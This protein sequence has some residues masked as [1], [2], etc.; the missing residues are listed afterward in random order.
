MPCHR[1]THTQTQICPSPFLFSTPPLSPCS[2]NW[3]T[4]V[5]TKFVLQ[6]LRQKRKVKVVLGHVS[7]GGLENTECATSPVPLQ[8]KPQKRLSVGVRDW[9][10]NTINQPPR[11]HQCWD[12]EAGCKSP[13]WMPPL[14]LPL[15]RLGGG[16]TWLSP[17]WWSWFRGW[18]SKVKWQLC[19]FFPRRGKTMKETEAKFQLQHKIPVW[20]CSNAGYICLVVSGLS[21]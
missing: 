20:L 1:L 13:L 9:T 15:Y 4:L 3:V 14:T 12:K 10:T 5:G 7:T 18:S 2:Y 11:G 6:A 21:S 8:P 16:L 17:F 19:G